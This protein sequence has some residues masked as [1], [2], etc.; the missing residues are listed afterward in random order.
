[1]GP[2][3]ID[4]YPMKA[5]FLQGEPLKIAVEVSNDAGSPVDFK[6]KS[7]MTS[8]IHEIECYEWEGTLSA[9]EQKKFEIE[10]NPKYDDFRGYGIDVSLYWQ[11]VR[12]QVM[13]SA[14]DVVSNWRKSPRYGFLSDFYSEDAGDWAD[15]ESLNKLHINMVQ[16][17][18]WMYKHDQLVPPMMEYTDLMGR[19]LNREVVQEKISLC[20]QYGMKAIAYGAVYAASKDYYDQHKDSALY[21]RKGQVLDFIDIFYIMNIAQDSP[22]HDHIINQYR[23]AIEQMDFDGIHMDTYGSPKTAV[24]RLNNDERVIRL[25]EHFPILINNTRSVLEA[26]K[27]DI[28]LIFNNVG[29]WPVDTVALAK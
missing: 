1:M 6:I 12:T 9:N 28:G 3:I 18:D 14:F 13:S 15:I 25:E 7:I 16:F 27:K 22:W 19:T 26:S 8:L 11:N 21:D 29:N 5:Q 20:H 17:Y 4:T 2:K 10:F 23:Q 24:S